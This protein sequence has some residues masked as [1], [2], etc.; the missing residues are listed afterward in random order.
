MKAVR[1]TGSIAL[2]CSAALLLFALMERLVTPDAALA[3]QER[4]SPILEFIR[5]PANE[6]APE[7][8]NRVRPKPPPEQALPEPLPAPKAETDANDIPDM[9][10]S[11][12]LPQLQRASRFAKGPALSA[13]QQAGGDLTG[14]MSVGTELTPLVRINPIYPLHLRRLK[15]EG[16]VRAK[17]HVDAQGNVTRV[18]IIQSNPQG[19]FDRA[20][21]EA[22]NRW[23]FRPKFVDGAKIAYTGLVTIEFKL[24]Q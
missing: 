21:I 4:R 22:L 6:A 14:P 19:R 2:G 10:V 16:E 12:A 11:P 5:I 1:F 20:V 24:V 23:K 9:P 3:L 8:P 17:L 15:I 7:A 13:A 18:D